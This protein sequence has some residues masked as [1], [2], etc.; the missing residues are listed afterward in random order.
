MHFYILIQY[1]HSAFYPQDSVFY[2]TML[3]KSLEP[4][5]ISVISIP[6]PSF[7]KMFWD[8]FLQSFNDFGFGYF[9]THFSVQNLIIFRE[10][11]LFNPQNSDLVIKSFLNSKDVP[12]LL[13]HIIIHLFDHF[14]PAAC[15][16]IKCSAFFSW[17]YEKCQHK[18]SEHHKMIP[19]KQLAQNFTCS[20]DQLNTSQVLL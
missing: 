3:C 6:S 16:K 8:I 20:K 12:V 9:V 2:Q 17:I 19:K 1:N 15:P 11:F 5:F 10:T 14:L 4:S 13:Q 18:I 7:K